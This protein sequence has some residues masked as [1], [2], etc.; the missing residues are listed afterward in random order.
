MADFLLLLFL[1]FLHALRAK[2][3]RRAEEQ[4]L[5]A[6]I[7]SASVLAPSVHVAADVRQAP[8]DLGCAARVVAGSP[9]IIADGTTV[10]VGSAVSPAHGFLLFCL[11]PD[12]SEDRAGQRQG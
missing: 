10:I 3:L 7:P 9:K 6:K 8:V 11:I 1:P 5:T 2:L 4:V 12:T